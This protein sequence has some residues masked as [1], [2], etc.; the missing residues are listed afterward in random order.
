L[1]KAVAQEGALDE[2]HGPQ[3]AGA[4]DLPQLLAEQRPYRGTMETRCLR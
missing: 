3:R 2:Q 4:R 1:K